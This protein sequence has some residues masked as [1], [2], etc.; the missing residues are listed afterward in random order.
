[1]PDKKDESSNAENHRDSIFRNWTSDDR[2]LLM[3][4]IVATVAANIVT[5]VVVALA[6]IIARS[7]RPNPGTP[8]NY[9]FLFGSS[10]F[11]LLAV[12]TVLHVLHTSKHE[13]K[14]D[15]WYQVVKWTLIAIGAFE[16]LFALLYIL[17]FI[18]FAT[19]IK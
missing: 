18:G 2:K 8:G 3:I 13:K 14:R 9:A 4:T 1:M 10:I 17:A 16:G 11:P 12:F 5:V 7:M 6:V 19:G 15:L